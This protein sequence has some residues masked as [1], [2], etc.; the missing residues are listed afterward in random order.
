MAAVANVRPAPTSPIHPGTANVRAFGFVVVLVMALAG[1]AAPPS[2]PVSAPPPP[3]HLVVINQTD[4]A[5][6]MVIG[7]DSGPPVQDFQ[8]QPR[9]SQTVDLPAGDYV[10]EQTALSENAEPGLSRKFSSRLESGQ[11]YRWRLATLLSESP[12]DSDA[13]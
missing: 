8:L 4:Y 7:R 9:G 6:H 12:S 5:W 13:R 1:C 11:T 10:I 2:P 3:A